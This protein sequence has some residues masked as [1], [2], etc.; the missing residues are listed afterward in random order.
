MFIPRL[1]T[2][3]LVREPAEILNKLKSTNKVKT[4]EYTWWVSVAM[5]LSRHD[6]EFFAFR[7][8]YDSIIFPIVN[9]LIFY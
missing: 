3:D 2:T 7:L 5:T 6:S 4:F 8:D 9:F 1:G